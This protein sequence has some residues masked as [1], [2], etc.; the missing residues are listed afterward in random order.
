MNSIWAESFG[1][2]LCFETGEILGRLEKG[3]QVLLFI[4]ILLSQK[5]GG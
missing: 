4:L 2:T 5:D 3:L 1:S